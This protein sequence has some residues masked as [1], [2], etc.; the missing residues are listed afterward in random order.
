M[1]HTSNISTN[2][3]RDQS[4]N[5]NYIPTPNAKEIFD[6]IFLHNYGANRSFN[7]IGNYGTGKSS[8]LWALEKNIKREEQFF[9]NLESEESLP[10][11]EFVPIIGKFSSLS[12]IIAV[13]LGIKQDDSNSILKALEVRRKKAEN[14]QLFTTSAV[15]YLTKAFTE[16]WVR[17]FT[18]YNPQQMTK[19]TQGENF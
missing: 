12:Q 16:R 11:F 7:L 19:L 15:T 2:I 13:N 3:L 18:K 4:K 6:R 14:L 17:W 10:L 1:N 8:F 9:T 5:I